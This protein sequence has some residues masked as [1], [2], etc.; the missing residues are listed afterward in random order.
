MGSITVWNNAS[1]SLSTLDVFIVFMDA[2]SVSPLFF[3]IFVE[4]FTVSFV[5]LNLPAH[6]YVYLCFGHCFSSFLQMSVELVFLFFAVGILFSWFLL[7]SL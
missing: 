7:S 1:G 2:S 3:V 5:F 4:L 6:E